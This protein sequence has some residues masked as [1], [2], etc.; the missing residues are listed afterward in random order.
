MDLLTI[1]DFNND[2]QQDIVVAN[3]GSDNVGIFLGNGDGSFAYQVT[4][5]TESGSSPYFVAVDD[6]DNDNVKDIIV[7]NYGTSNIGVLLGR[8]DGTF[9]KSTPLGTKYG[10]H[11]FWIGIGD[12]NK[13]KKLDFAIANNGTTSIHI[14]L[15]TC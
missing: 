5:S 6:I 8:G 10:S 9:E 3:Y 7:A 13:D 14:L 1:N 4:Y 12:F 15:Q 2:N 11:P